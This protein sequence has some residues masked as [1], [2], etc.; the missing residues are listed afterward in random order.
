MPYILVYS[1]INSNNA[2]NN[3]TNYNISTWKHKVQS[4]TQTILTLIILQSPPP[5]IP[6][7]PVC[8]TCIVAIKKPLFKL[9]QYLHLIS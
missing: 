4:L 5:L 8:K 9:F 1:G 3:Y 7:L 2:I 6:W